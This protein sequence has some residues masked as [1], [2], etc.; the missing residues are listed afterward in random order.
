MSDINRS[1]SIAK[2]KVKV[3]VTPKSR[4]IGSF[5]DFIVTNIL[6]TPLIIS[7]YYVTLNYIW[8]AVLMSQNVLPAAS[9]P[10]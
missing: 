9:V 1:I 6:V 2:V 4:K 5:C 3:K 8:E 10:W 7:T